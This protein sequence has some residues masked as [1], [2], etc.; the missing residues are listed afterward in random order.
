LKQASIMWCALVPAYELEVE[1]Q[2]GGARHGAEELLGGLVLEAVDVAG[3]QPQPAPRAVGAPET[4]IAQD[5]RA[6]SIGTTAC[7]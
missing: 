7:P 3:R 4:S 6:S 5:A 2:P 1:R